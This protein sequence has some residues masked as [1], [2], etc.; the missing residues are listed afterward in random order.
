MDGYILHLC[1]VYSL[2]GFSLLPV[3]RYNVCVHSTSF[4]HM[5]LSFSLRM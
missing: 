1:V 3:T 2:E 4:I 5:W